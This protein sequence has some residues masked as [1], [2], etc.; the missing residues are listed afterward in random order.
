MEFFAENVI[1]CTTFR[2]KLVKEVSVASKEDAGR[3][4]YGR[5]ACSLTLSRCRSSPTTGKI[6]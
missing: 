3:L 1:T 2:E 6:F 4:V 5:A